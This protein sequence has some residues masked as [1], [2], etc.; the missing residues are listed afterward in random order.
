M[1][2]ILISEKS[3]NFAVICPI[4]LR[5]YEAK[6]DLLSVRKP[7]LFANPHLYS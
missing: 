7:V 1:A 4:G 3:R 5:V 6:D 2:N